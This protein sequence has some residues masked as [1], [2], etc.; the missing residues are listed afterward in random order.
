MQVAM[1]ARTVIIEMKVRSC[2]HDRW[3]VQTKVMVL[4]MG[5]VNERKQ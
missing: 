3:G 1:D 5:K 4:L 2:L